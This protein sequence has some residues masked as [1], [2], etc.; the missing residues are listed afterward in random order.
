MNKWVTRH[1]PWRAASLYRAC[2]VV[3]VLC[4]AAPAFAQRKANGPFTQSP[5][6]SPQAH[7]LFF[8]LSGIRIDDHGLAHVYGRGLTTTPHA[9]GQVAVILWDERGVVKT[10]GGDVFAAQSSLGHGNVQTNCL[11]QN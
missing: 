7:S 11:T 8:R 10:G 9:S 2:A 1:A 5:A 4:S 6:N 3:L